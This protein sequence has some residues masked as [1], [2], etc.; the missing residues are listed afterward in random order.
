VFRRFLV[1]VVIFLIAVVVVADRVGAIVAA[2]VL[3]SK[4]QT[5][6]HLPNRPSASI[7]GIP[8][9]TQAFGGNYKSVKLTAPGVLVNQVDVTTLTVDLH[10]VH[11]P[12]S[13][14]IQGKVSEVPVDRA[15]GTAFISF[16]D[17]N[18]YLANHIIG[19]SLISLAPGSNGSAKV[20]DRL[21]V[22]GTL[23]SLHGLGSVAVANNVV[24]VGVRNF[25]GSKSSAG[26]AL[27]QTL[28]LALKRLKISFPLTGLPFQLKVRSVTVTP[29]GLSGT[30]SAA[31]IILGS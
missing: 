6:E 26:S 19:G 3:A 29:T 17:A 22:A 20:T 27:S 2:H 13:K 1:V 31:N 30:A 23:V 21:H 12:F 16:A 7:G 14:V 18:N 15:N 8:F 9:L 24:T 28:D 5:D 25:S 11:L 10:G 4:V